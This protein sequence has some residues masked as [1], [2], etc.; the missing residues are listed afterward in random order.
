MSWD[1]NWRIDGEAAFDDALDFA[2]TTMR[3]VG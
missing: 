3:K 1:G 2:A